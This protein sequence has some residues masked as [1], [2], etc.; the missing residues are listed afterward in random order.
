MSAFGGLCRRAMRLSWVSFALPTQANAIP[1]CHGCC[2]LSG[3]GARG[4]GRVTIS[5][6]EKEL[7]PSGK[8]GHFEGAP[9]CRGMNRGGSWCAVEVDG[10]VIVTIIYTTPSPRSARMVSEV[11]S[12]GPERVG[13]S[14]DPHGSIVKKACNL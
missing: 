7:I 12:S 2:K 8:L 6:T 10:S 11:M 14:C 5:S 9:C 4:G 1:A 3:H 13:I